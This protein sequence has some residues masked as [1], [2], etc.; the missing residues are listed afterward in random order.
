MWQTIRQEQGTRPRE[1][2]CQKKVGRQRPSDR[3]GANS[4]PSHRTGD[5]VSSVHVDVMM[6]FKQ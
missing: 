6:D 3:A 1:N 2:C 4:K 5:R